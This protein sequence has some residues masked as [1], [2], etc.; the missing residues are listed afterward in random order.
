MYIEDVSPGLTALCALGTSGIFFV[1]CRWGET[2]E[3][4]KVDRLCVDVSAYAILI[5]W[6]MHDPRVTIAGCVIAIL[7]ATCPTAIAAWKDPEK[8]S[9]M[10]WFLWLAGSIIFLSTC[11]QDEWGTL[12]TSIAIVIEETVMVVILLWQIPPAT[13]LSRIRALL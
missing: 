8:E 2:T 4:S 11:Q 5:G 12:A 7:I 9:L 6:A 3:L 13:L 1:S 10:T